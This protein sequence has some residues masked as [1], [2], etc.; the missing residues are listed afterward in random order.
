VIEFQEGFPLR[1]LLPLKG[2][3]LNLAGTENGFHQ[4]DQFPN[5]I[6][7]IHIGGQAADNIQG[8]GVASLFRVS[9]FQEAF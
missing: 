6:D 4:I 8:H 9:R 2:E 1:P 7:F 5:D 3:V